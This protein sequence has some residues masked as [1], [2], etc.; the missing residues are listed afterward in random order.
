MLLLFQ[1]G[2]ISMCFS[3]SFGQK[4]FWQNL[5]CS[6]FKHIHSTFPPVEFLFSSSL[7]VDFCHWWQSSTPQGQ[8]HRTLDHKL[9]RVKRQ[10][11]WLPEYQVCSL[12]TPAR[13]SLC[14]AVL[15]HTASQPTGCA[16]SLK[17]TGI[18]NTQAAHHL[19]TQVRQSSSS[20][21]NLQHLR[22]KERNNRGN[23]QTNR[24]LLYVREA[25]SVKTLTHFQHPTP[26]W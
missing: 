10:S 24:L 26:F 15:S 9:N 23:T 12:W 16:G 4:C 6:S 5:L 2:D 8:K 20:N 17:Y 22:I 21:I 18:N 1:P 11:G 14:D 13:L 7:L 25:R 3:F 19:C